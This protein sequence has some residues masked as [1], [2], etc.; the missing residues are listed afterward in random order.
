VLPCCRALA[1]LHAHSHIPFLQL[2]VTARGFCEK[3]RF[4]KPWLLTWSPSCGIT[5]LV[6]HADYLPS[7]AGICKNQL[8]SQYTSH[9]LPAADPFEQT[10]AGAASAIRGTTWK[11]SQRPAVA[12]S[13]GNAGTTVSRN[14]ISGRAGKSQLH[15]ATMCVI[16]CSWPV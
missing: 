9:L 3:R 16:I 8:A 1:F 2:T 4:A 7:S 6:H 15:V 12:I 14:Y 11:N 10:G 5:T 13:S